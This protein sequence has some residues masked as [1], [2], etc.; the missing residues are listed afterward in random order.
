MKTRE[1][2]LYDV[3]RI[4]AAAVERIRSLTPEEAARQAYRPGGP[5]VEELTAKL[6]AMRAADK[7][8]A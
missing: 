2:A 8:S 7:S 1:Q 3:G 4:V 6:R 5:S